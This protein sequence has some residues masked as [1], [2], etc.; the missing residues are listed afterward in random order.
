MLICY[1]LCLLCQIGY[2]RIERSTIK[3]IGTC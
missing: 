2:E 1:L 3:D